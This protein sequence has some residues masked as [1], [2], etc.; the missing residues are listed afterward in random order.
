MQPSNNIQ[1]LIN[2]SNSMSPENKTNPQLAYKNDPLSQVHRISSQTTIR[3]EILK[4]QLA[5]DK[6]YMER[7]DFLYPNQLASTARVN[8]KSFYATRRKNLF[9]SSAGNVNYIENLVY[10]IF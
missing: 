8:Y 7:T 1:A 3:P 6:L 9:I 5:I 2:S 4:L 10:D